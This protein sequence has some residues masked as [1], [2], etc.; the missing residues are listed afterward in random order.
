[1]S[2]QWRNKRRQEGLRPVC[3]GET[4]CPRRKSVQSVRGK[5]YQF[6]ERCIIYLSFVRKIVGSILFPCGVSND[7]HLCSLTIGRQHFF[8]HYLPSLL[9]SSLWCYDK[10]GAFSILSATVLYDLTPT[11]YSVVMYPFCDHAAVLV[12]HPLLCMA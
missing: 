8:T 10:P 5:Q 2:S 9:T 11:T 6:E 7:I 3:G 1:M 12:I 4:L